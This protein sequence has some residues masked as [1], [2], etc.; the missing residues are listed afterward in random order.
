M[1]MRVTEKKFGQEIFFYKFDRGRGVE[2]I[3]QARDWLM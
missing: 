1:C 3:N 2:S